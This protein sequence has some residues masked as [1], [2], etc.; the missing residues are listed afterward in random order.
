MTPT[1]GKFLASYSKQNYLIILA[2][3]LKIQQLTLS[4]KKPI[5]YRNQSI[6]LLCKSM[7]WFLYDIGLRRDRVK[8]SIEGPILLVFVNLSQ[9]FSEGFLVI[10]INKVQSFCYT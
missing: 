10:A 4:R 8:L 6:D 2:E 1:K 5:S 9:I 7:D 3:K